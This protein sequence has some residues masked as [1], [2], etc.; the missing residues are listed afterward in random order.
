MAK[1]T[2]QPRWKQLQKKGWKTYNNGFT[3]KMF[4][5][6]ARAESAGYYFLGFPDDAYS[7]ARTHFHY[8]DLREKRKKQY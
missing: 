1:N 7:S 5:S 2:K 4:S 3:S 8:S 6:R